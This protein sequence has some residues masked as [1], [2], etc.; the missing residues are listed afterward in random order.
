M[1]NKLKRGLLL[2]DVALAIL[3]IIKTYQPEESDTNN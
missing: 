3:Q 1:S 2:L